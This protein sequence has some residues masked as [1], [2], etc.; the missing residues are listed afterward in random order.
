MP[1]YNANDINP[2]NEFWDFLNRQFSGEFKLGTFVKAVSDV[3]NSASAVATASL[4]LA[5]GTMT[6]GIVLAAGG[7]DAVAAVNVGTSTA[8][9][10]NVGTAVGCAVSIGEVTGTAAF[11]CVASGIDGVAVTDLATVNQLS[12][13]F[14]SVGVSAEVAHKRILSGTYVDQTGTPIAASSN[15][16]LELYCSVAPTALACEAASGTNLTSDILTK[17]AFL[18]FQT[19][20]DG[21]FAIGMTFA[22]ATDVVYKVTGLSAEPYVSFTTFD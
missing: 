3:A 8:T 21:T 14:V 18:A 15:C 13:S 9:G 7:V 10:V 16:I 4:P 6:G 12:K 2:L 20:A 11:N 1:L 22:G 5:G 19:A 17:H